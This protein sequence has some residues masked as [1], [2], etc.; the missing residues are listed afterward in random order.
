MRSQD[1]GNIANGCSVQAR[2]MHKASYHHGFSYSLAT[3]QVN[4]IPHHNQRRAIL[5]RRA[6]RYAD[7]P[8]R[9]TG[10]PLLPFGA[11]PS[12]VSLTV[13]RSRRP[14]AT[15]SVSHLTIGGTLGKRRLHRRSRT[16]RQWTQ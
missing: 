1:S 8:L 4:A 14:F 15:Q 13:R 9:A 11:R 10:S 7:L 16:T 6:G 5:S 2:A 12:P 3:R